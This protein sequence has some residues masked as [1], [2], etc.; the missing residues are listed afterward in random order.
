MHFQSPTN[1]PIK[2]HSSTSGEETVRAAVAAAAAARW[3]CGEGWVGDGGRLVFGLSRRHTYTHTTHTTA[4]LWLA[5]WKGEEEGLA[6]W[7]PSRNR[8]V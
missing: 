8:V 4:A 3:G 2:N 6:F 1:L 5:V 7:K